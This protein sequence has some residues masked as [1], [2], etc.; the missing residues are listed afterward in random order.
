M[1]KCAIHQDIILSE[2]ELTS[3]QD[4]GFIH[5]GHILDH[6]TLTILHAEEQRFRSLPQEYD[7]ADVHE[8]GTIF[9]SQLMFSST[10]IRDFCA[11]G[12]HITAMEQLIGPNVLLMYSQLVTKF[13]EDS[14]R[15]HT[16]VFPWH[17][18]NG[19]KSIIPANNVTVWTALNDVDEQNGCVWVIPGSHKHGLLD[20]HAAA[21]G[22]WHKEAPVEDSGIPVPLRAGEAVAFT[23]LTLHR[24]L[25]NTS[26]A[27]RRGFFMEY[28]DAQ[29]RVES[30]GNWV[31]REPYTWMVA[32][33]IDNMN[34]EQIKKDQH[35]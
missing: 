15:D 31:W 25:T 35:S 22:S 14:V 21:S 18:D 7:S 32:G 28:C 26:S 4:H 2:K 24:S 9:R 30:N 29:G 34:W 33:Q 20:H 11:T 23:G 8:S 12:P 19:Y 5:L 6:H 16:T 1:F 17:Q 27:P 3:F 13:P 10:A